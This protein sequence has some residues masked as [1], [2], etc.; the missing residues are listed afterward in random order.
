VSDRYDG[1]LKHEVDFKNGFVEIPL[2]L[3]VS[4]FPRTFSGSEVGKLVLLDTDRN[5]GFWGADE[6]AYW[7]SGGDA[8]WKRGGF[9]EDLYEDGKKI[10]NGKEEKID[11]LVSSMHLFERTGI[12]ERARKSAAES[13]TVRQ[14]VDGFDPIRIESW[15]AIMAFL[16]EYGLVD[17]TEGEN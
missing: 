1:S 10:H 11:R 8:E 3:A 7:L 4:M 14:L 16:E 6:V 2:T 5:E 17:D 15:D 9:G 13:K 12:A